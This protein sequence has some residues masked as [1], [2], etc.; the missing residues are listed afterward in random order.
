MKLYVRNGLDIKKADTP[1][2][3]NGH[4]AVNGDVG[5]VNGGN[6][7]GKEKAPSGTF[8]RVPEYLIMHEIS[9]YGLCQPIFARYQV[10]RCI[11]GNFL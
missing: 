5:K 8:K 2:S 7:A 9:K 4:E 3:S 11:E 6:E 1:N 10:S